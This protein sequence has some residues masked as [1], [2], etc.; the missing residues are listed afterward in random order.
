VTITKE[1]ETNRDTLRLETVPRR[2][3]KILS[4][5]P[6]IIMPIKSDIVSFECTLLRYESYKCVSHC[7]LLI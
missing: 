1:Y 2:Y 7:F 4:Y 3:T 6:T 5:I